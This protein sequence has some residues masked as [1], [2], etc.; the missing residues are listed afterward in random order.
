VNFTHGAGWQE[1]VTSVSDLGRW[2]ES[3][4]HIAGWSLEHR[5]PAD[6]SLIRAWALPD[7][8]TAEEAILVC[9]AEPGRWLRLI[10]FDDAQQEQIRSSGQAWETGGIFSIL[11]YAA[12]TRAAFERAQEIGWSAHNDPVVMAFGGR[13]L[14]NVVLRGPDGCN[15]GLYQPI[16]PEPETPPPFPK[17]G[18]PF[19]AQQMVR[20]TAKTESF[21]QA[22]LG[23][24]S[25]YSGETR[26]A[27]NNFG[28][29]ENMIGVHAKDVAIMHA[30]P[31]SHGQ[32]ELVQWN[33]FTGRDFASRAVPPNLGH[34]ALRW[35]VSDLDEY[36]NRIHAS[37]YTLF[38]EPANCLLAPMGDVRI[39]SVRSPDGVIIELVEPTE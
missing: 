31:D 19:T 8:V 9:P 32:V 28:V 17:L 12:D 13:E 25:W 21:Y 27:C 18:P 24:D 35:P 37:G 1:A 14:A 22:A 30:V 29:P 15:F 39:C 23:W 6:A 20:D 5:G 7:T 11:I 36:V 3:M 2:I 34:L 10:S 26:L 38:T 33:G 16:K 4:Q